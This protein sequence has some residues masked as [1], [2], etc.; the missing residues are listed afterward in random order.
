MVQSPLAA[1]AGGLPDVEFGVGGAGCER[2]P[3]SMAAARIQTAK[4]TPPRVCRIGDVGPLIRFTGFSSFL[5][6]DRIL[7]TRCEGAAKQPLGV[8]PDNDSRPSDAAA[9]VGISM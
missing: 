9:V 1:A 3:G 7:R 8:Q 6:V 4:T 5:T 2:A